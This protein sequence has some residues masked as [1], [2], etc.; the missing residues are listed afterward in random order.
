MTAGIEFDARD[1]V[2]EVTLD[3]PPGNLWDATMLDAAMQRLGAAG[4]EP[5]LLA[6]RL[7]ARGEAFCLGRERGARE[8]AELRAEARRLADTLHVWTNTPLLTLAEVH[9]DAAGFG[10]NLAGLADVAIAA[11]TARLS[12]PEIRGGLA[13]TLVLSWL[14]TYV[15]YKRAMQLVTTGQAIDAATACSMGLVT[16]VVPLPALAGAVEDLLATWREFD[17]QALREIKRF[18]VSTRY[19]PPDRA[20]NVAADAL[21][22]SALAGRGHTA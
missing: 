5:D 7:R 18:V 21:A 6:I 9:G 16:R 12:F 15:G 22:L 20:A 8:P 4:S 10:A 17:R 3:R 19:W 13:P 14:P 11:D 2:L 1:G